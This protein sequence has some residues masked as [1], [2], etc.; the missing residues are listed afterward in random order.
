MRPVPLALA[1]ASAS[2]A[3]VTHS[4]HLAPASAVVEVTPS[5]ASIELERRPVQCRIEFFRL[6]PPERPFDEV[7][8]LH[9]RSAGLDADLGGALGAQELMR[10]RACRIGAHAVVVTQDYALGGMRQAMSPGEAIMTGTA[11]AYRGYRALDIGQPDAAPAPVVRTA[12][13]PITDLGR[14]AGGP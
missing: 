4:G 8:T 5:G 2:C 1:L 13:E 14:R 3:V 7:A 9:F 10:E 6:R 12:P 11:I